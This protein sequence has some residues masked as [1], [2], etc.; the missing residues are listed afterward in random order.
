MALFLRKYLI[1]FIFLFLAFLLVQKAIW[2]KDFF[3]ERTNYIEILYNFTV[4]YDG[5]R[6]TPLY[7][8]VNFILNIIIYPFIAALFW[9]LVLEKSKT[10]SIINNFLFKIKEKRIINFFFNFFYKI[11]LNYKIYF[12]FCLIF[13]FNKLDFFDFLHVN[14][15]LEKN[16]QLYH[17]P[18][19][20]NFINPEKKKNLILFFTESL[21][22]QVRSLDKNNPIKDIDAVK[23]NNIN[24]FKHAPATAFSIGAVVSTQCSVP[25]YPTIS[26]NLTT[27][28]KNDLI[29]LSD[30]LNRFNYKQIFYLTVHADF[31]GFGIFKRLHSFE[32]YDID[33]MVRDGLAEERLTGWANGV[34]DDDMLEHAKNKIIELHQSGQPFNVTL[35][36]ADTHYPFV[37]SPRCKEKI[38]STKNKKLKYIDDLKRSYRCSGKFINNFFKDL[39]KAGV[40]EDTVVVLMG[41][42]L[43]ADREEFTIPD[44][45]D[46]NIYF[47]M[48]NQKKF[49]RAKINHFDIAPTILDEMGILPDDTSRYGFGYSAVREIKNY[50]QHYTDVMDKKILSEYLTHK[51]FNTAK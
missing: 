21:E 4:Q 47:K 29:C 13:Y 38:L 42:H 11:I 39:E 10:N 9:M 23:G 18:N 27:F 40:L 22:T 30:I 17:N 32:V 35:I 46:R 31:H 20:I 7:Y 6:D 28:K 19:K 51:I 48:N 8:K 49:K 1:N 5:V 15:N 33:K 34:H 26:M 2:I 43:M 16:I 37:S 14:K 41:D 3:G 12:I 44:G 25:F 36:T 45:W 50:D 24:N